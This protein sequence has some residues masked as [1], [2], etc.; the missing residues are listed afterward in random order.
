LKLLTLIIALCVFPL[1]QSLA[2]NTIDLLERWKAGDIPTAQPMVGRPFTQVDWITPDHRFHIHYDT[3]GENAVYNPHEDVNPMDRIPDYVNRTADYLALSYDT[4]VI[5]LGFD[6]PPFDGSEGGDSLYDIYLTNDLG[7]TTP[8]IPSNQYPGRPAFSSFIQLGHDLRYPSRYGDDPNPFLKISVAHEYFHAIEFAYRAMSSDSTFWWFESC[9][10]WAEERVFDNIN[11]A[12]YSLGDYLSRPQKS[13]YNTDGAFLYGAWLWPEFL[14]ERFGSAFIVRCWEEFTDFDFAL[15]AINYALQHENSTINDEFCRHVVWN[16]FTG[17]NYRAGFYDEGA[18]FD[19][20]VYEARLHTSYP[21]DWVLAPLALQNMSTSYIVFENYNDLKSNLI[22]E[23]RN[24]TLDNQAV[25]IAV[26]KPS[27]PVQYNFYFIQTIVS[28]SFTIRDFNRGDKVIM[29]PVWL[30]ESDP[31]EYLT[32]YL[33][34]AFLR[35]S[36]TAISENDEPIQGYA[37]DG[38]YPNPFNGAVSITFSAPIAKPYT[39]HIYDILG[40]PV[41]SRDGISREGINSLNWQAPADLASGVLFY[42]ID[43]GQKR[44]DGKM[45]LLK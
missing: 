7:S 16:Y 43:F 1:S 10:K 24:Y 36:L 44:L 40:R 4:L 38:V 26:V 14:D 20:T 45:S 32:T 41:M 37:L 27:L 18:D 6:P 23:Y 11:D 22:I 30:Y 35:D 3:T 15:T 21:V 19:T 13:L 39:I 34:R 12:Y 2:C 31:K 28:Q 29:M 25:C 17:N 5:S 33:Y 42:V 9:A 8:E